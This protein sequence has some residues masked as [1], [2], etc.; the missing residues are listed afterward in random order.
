MNQ[1]VHNTTVSIDISG[2]TCASC[3]ARVERALLKV[4]EVT[5]ASV[6]LATER[7]TVETAGPA[8]IAPLLAAV[9]K[10]GYT[11]TVTPAPEH[12]HDHAG[13]HHHDEDAA[14]L[15][16]DVLI[17][18]IP[19]IP[20]FAAEMLGHFYMPFHMW[21]M[22]LVGMDALYVTYFALATF[23]LFVPGWRFF[24]I[25]IPALLRGAPEMNS[26]VALGAGAAWLY[27]T[28][29][30]FAPHLLPPGTRNVYFESAAVI[31]TLIL[32]GRLLEA[33]AKGRT[34]E[35]IQRLVR[36]QPRTARVERNGAAADIEVADVRVGDVII[37]RPGEKI[38]VDGTVI[39]GEAHVD[40]SMLSG[41]PL[42][43][44]K[45]AGASVT[46]GTINTGGSIRFQATRVGS[47]TVL[48]QI[49]RMVED[50]QA[51]KLPI[52]QVVDRV[53]FWFVPAVIVVALATFAAWAIWGGSLSYGLVNAVA[54]LIIACPCAMGLATPTAI[55][56]GT[57]RAAELGV[58]FRRGEA[59]QQLQQADVV[60][61]DKTGTLTVG[62]PVLTDIILDDDF[63]HDQVLALVAAAESRSEHP[64]AT[65]IV[66]AAEQAGLA[67]PSVEG[68]ESLPGRGIVATIADRRVQVGSSRL[69]D[70]L[71][72]GDFRSTVEQ[73]TE[74]G[75]T[76]VFVAIDGKPAAAI[77]VADVVKPNSADAI[78]ALHRLGIR[79]AMISGDDRRTA[80][81][82]ARELGIDEVRAEVLPADKAEVVRGLRSGGR[83]VAFVGDG[84]NDAP[85]LAEADVGIAVGNGTDVAIESADVVLV[86]GDPR[87]VLDAITVSRAT[88]RNIRENLFWA[89]GYN[90]LLV[91]VAAGLLYPT[92]GW[93]LSPMLAAGAMAASSVLVVGNAQRLRLVKGARA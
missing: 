38:A 92:F 18:A 73:V 29:V 3:V 56:V 37:V 19:T 4:P 80:A 20:L 87:G 24:R 84:I 88:M 62:K 54:V 1:H 9:G 57:G 71:D 7:A 27:S 34:G 60:A 49:I 78:A 41:E 13:H 55:M 50:A 65:A 83:T 74:A 15:R 67:I 43:V 44:T 21:L 12:R 79:T 30:T 61:F 8:K 26:L 75:R 72:L 89:F 69:L 23:V 22:D 52:Q 39:D 81:A 77:G 68:F 25:G 36:Q 14:V 91:P 58:L 42:P 46:G 93:L 6:N 35:A 33:L 82:I 48:A 17:A 16:R 70:G 59:L 64:I 76:A 90:V 47:D 66:A 11:A 85:A 28:V 32:L 86:G 40:E 63:E 45:A 51:G 53:T 31:V 10:A 2:M 5:S